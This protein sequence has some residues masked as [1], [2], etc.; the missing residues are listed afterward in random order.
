[1]AH[2]Q[3]V[4]GGP[5]PGTRPLILSF[6]AVA[7]CFVSA[8]VYSQ[9]YARAIDQLAQSIAGNAMPS[10]EHLT[11]ARSEVR[12]VGALA[13]SVVVA[14]P[15]ERAFLLSEIALGQ[16]AIDA[17]VDAYLRL[18]VY[19]NE[20]ELWKNIR[21]DLEE[22]HRAVAG[23]RAAASASDAT[24]V[25]ASADE[26]RGAC[27]NAV[28]AFMRDI[29]LNAENGRRSAAQIAEIRH[30]S[31][32]VSTAV[33]VASVLLTGIL[34]LM[35]VRAVRAHS[36][37]LRRHAELEAERSDE[38]DQFAGRVAHDIRNP[39]GAIGM[40]L[41]V[42]ATM[43]DNP[44]LSNLVARCQASLQRA[45][46]ILDG[47][48]D[49]ARAGGRP[50]HGVTASVNEVVE[51]LL[52][53]VR[54]QAQESRVEVRVEPFES[55]TV[56]CDPALLTVLLSNLV[57]NAIK[58]I[59]DGPVRVVSLR[60]TAHDKLVRIEVEDTG[61]GV[62]PELREA[63][64]QPFTR[65]RNPKQ[66]GVGLGLA[67]VSRICDRHGGR[68]GLDSSESGGSRFWVE[69]PRAQPA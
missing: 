15:A 30:R 56:A 22:V 52:E 41:A 54:P 57:R 60:A 29:S 8:T 10:I 19:T 23:L 5:A 32:V 42:I 64:F 39:L 36:A 6:I 20:G 31:L 27:E 69:L 43:A 38:L 63:I 13:Q 46:R 65:G 3:R 61:V 14:S 2:L 7:A 66:P 12:H 48:L 28:S 55:F 50:A 44:K 9:L 16:S 11:A 58:Y 24:Q 26:I 47:L 25:K 1:M 18:P 34:A 49:F 53:A 59:G 68:V 51:E 33:I 37:F 67:T 45:A 4:T 40:N 17:E 35:A 21:T 62:P